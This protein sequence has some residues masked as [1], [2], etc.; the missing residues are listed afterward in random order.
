MEHGIDVVK[1]ILFTKRTGTPRSSA[2]TTGRLTARTIPPSVVYRG[3]KKLGETPLELEMP[4]GTYTLMFKNPSRAAVT[5]AV[6]I[7]AGKTAKL[8]FVLPRK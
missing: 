8:D 2:P 4:A 6:T 5:K 7:S 1:E 3:A